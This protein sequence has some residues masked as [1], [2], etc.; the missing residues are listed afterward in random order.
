MS[1][2]FHRSRLL[3]LTLVEILVAL[4]MTLIV[5]GA[6]ILWIMAAV[7]RPIYDLF[8][9]IKQYGQ[10]ALPLIRTATWTQRGWWMKI[11]A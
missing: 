5:L 1:T 3:G 10:L 8:T 11:S 9:Q 7:M 2:K 4:V 6:M